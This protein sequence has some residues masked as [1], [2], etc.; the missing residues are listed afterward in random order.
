M[1]TETTENMHRQCVWKAASETSYIGQVE[2]LTPGVI[3][4]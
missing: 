2:L 1:V 3:Y 4:S